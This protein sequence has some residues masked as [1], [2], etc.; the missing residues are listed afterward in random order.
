LKEYK[1]PGYILEA[2]QAVAHASDEI[3]A[4]EI[5]LQKKL[6]SFQ[7]SEKV[8]FFSGLFKFSILMF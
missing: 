7:V 2:I 5:W 1:I 6:V 8:S 3:E 4:E